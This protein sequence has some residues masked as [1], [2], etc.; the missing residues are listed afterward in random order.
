MDRHINEFYS[1][2]SDETPSGHFHKVIALNDEPQIT[3]QEIA[4][5][6]PALCKGWFELSRLSPADRLEF[7]CDYW[8]LRMPYHPE[9]KD[10]L[11]TFF[12][13]LDDIGVFV[14]QKKFDDP[15]RAELV[16]S[17]KGGNGFFRGTIG[18]TEEQVMRMQKEFSSYFLPKDYLSFLQ[19]HNGFSKTTDCT[20]VIPCSEIK[21]T[22][23][24]FQEMINALH[25]IETTSGDLVEAKSLIPFYESFGMPFFQCFYGEWYPGE[26]MGN[27][28]Y[29][30][31]TNTISDVKGH[32]MGPENM[33]FPT[34][35]DWLMFYLEKVQ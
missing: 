22:Y 35:T 26:E 34:F 16:Y 33:S 8:L 2:F 3:W 1:V 24:N 6:I 27:V 10:F 15:Y 25:P 13:E 21:E 5:K 28:Y 29:S 17:C 14:Y 30:G 12:N 19:I 23:L 32:L 11:I 18:A 9:L 7:L 20:G 31:V 4:Q